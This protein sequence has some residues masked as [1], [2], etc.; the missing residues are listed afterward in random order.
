[1]S[2]AVIG[3]SVS[4]DEVEKEARP[5]QAADFVLLTKGTRANRTAAIALPRIFGFKRDAEDRKLMLWS[6][7]ERVGTGR[8]RRAKEETEQRKGMC[9]GHGPWSYEFTIVSKSK[10]STNIVKYDRT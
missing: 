10:L 4:E 1:M 3:L 7:K 8:C 5:T 9:H 2:T 6:K